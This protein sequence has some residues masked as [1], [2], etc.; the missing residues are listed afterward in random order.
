MSLKI[1][2]REIINNSRLSE[3]YTR[4]SM[5]LRFSVAYDTLARF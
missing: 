5:L 2:L 1:V 3:E 4:L